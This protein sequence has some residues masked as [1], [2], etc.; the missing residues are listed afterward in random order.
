MHDFSFFFSFSFLPLDKN[1]WL[2]K[3]KKRTGCFPRALNTRG[4]EERFIRVRRNLVTLYIY[5]RVSTI[6]GI[7]VRG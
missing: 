4:R 1:S 3:R 2:R 7:R 5:S 6:R